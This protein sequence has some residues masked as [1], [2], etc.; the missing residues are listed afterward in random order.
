MSQIQQNEKK[1]EISFYKDLSY[2]E[3]AKLDFEQL[4]SVIINRIKEINNKMSRIKA[5]NNLLLLKSEIEDRFEANI[6]RSESRFEVEA[7]FNSNKLEGI[8]ITYFKEDEEK[9]KKF[10]IGFYTERN[11]YG[12]VLNDNIIVRIYHPEVK[13]YIT[14]R[15]PKIEINQEKII[16]NN[17][18]ALFKDLPRFTEKLL[19]GLPIKIDDTNITTV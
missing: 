13:V 6:W 18:K 9:I 14:E 17:I 8:Y 5:F 16:I 2:K 10:H 12:F 19:N 7:E 11:I 1:I 4:K 3:P 15:L